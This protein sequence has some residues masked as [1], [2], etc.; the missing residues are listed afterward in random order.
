[1]MTVLLLLTD[2]QQGHE[3]LWTAL[4]TLVGNGGMCAHTYDMYSALHIRDECHMHAPC[5]GIVCTYAV[6][7]TTHSHESTPDR[8]ILNLD[9][10]QSQAAQSYLHAVARNAVSQFWAYCSYAGRVCE[11]GAPEGNC[12]IKMIGLGDGVAAAHCLP[13]ALDRFVE[14]RVS[15]PPPPPPPLGMQHA[16]N[17]YSENWRFTV[18]V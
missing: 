6:L 14:G 15:K 3:I 18:E 16:G 11:S 7:D 17:L 13:V 9:A 2:S 12:I 10:G 8:Q 5:Y 4:G 1:M